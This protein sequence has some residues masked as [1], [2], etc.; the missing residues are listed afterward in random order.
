MKKKT[1]ERREKTKEQ[2]AANGWSSEELKLQ[3]LQLSRVSLS[4]IFPDIISEA[5]IKRLSGGD[6][7]PG[8]GGLLLDQAG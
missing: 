5:T 7:W 6:I 4:H 3:E 8:C 1:Y 2:R